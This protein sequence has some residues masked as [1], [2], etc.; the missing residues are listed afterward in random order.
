MSNKMEDGIFIVYVLVLRN[1]DSIVVA[2]GINLF[3]IKC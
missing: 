2:L 1:F 3:R